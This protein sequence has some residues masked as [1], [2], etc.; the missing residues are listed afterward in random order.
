M[1]SGRCFRLEREQATL[2]PERRTGLFP[3]GFQTLWINNQISKGIQADDEIAHDGNVYVVI[4]KEDSD[5]PNTAVPFTV[6]YERSDIPTVIEPD[7][8]W[9]DII[10][11]NN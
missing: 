3:T 5:E 6:S 2:G 10:S 1:K 9:P 11:E 8:E 7:P 4:S